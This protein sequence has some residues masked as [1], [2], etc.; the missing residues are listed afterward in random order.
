MV[1]YNTHFIP[2]NK[3][4]E[5]SDYIYVYDDTKLVGKVKTGATTM[6][7]LGEKLYSF[8]ALSDVHVNN[9]AQVKQRFEN[10]IKYFTDEEQAA[11]TCIAG[12]LTGSGTLEH[13]QEYI[14]SAI[15]AIK[16]CS[17]PAIVHDTTGNHDVQQIYAPEYF[18]APYLDD[19]EIIEEEKTAL[20]I[21]KEYAETQYGKSY[22]ELGI[23][24]EELDVFRNR[25]TYY[26]F[27]QGDDVFIM[28]GMYGWISKTGDTFTL[29]SLK[30]LYETLEANRNKRCFVFEHCP[31]MIYVNAD[32]GV[33]KDDGSGKPFNSTTSGSIL[34]LRLPTGN[35][36]NQGTYGLPF[37]KLMAH[38][39]NVIWFHGHSHMDFHYQQ[40]CSQVNYDKNFGCHS[41]HIPSL[42]SGRR[43]KADGSGWENPAGGY[44]YVVDVYNGHIVLRGRDFLN[45]EF[46]PITTFYLDTTLQ[47]IE[48]STFTEITGITTT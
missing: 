29:E 48:A 17:Q 8:G 3:A 13:Y 28:F 7:P 11:F 6:P 44:G 25:K 33:L 39:K 9:S 19:V 36:L 37:R 10:T 18:L 26:S 32:T 15:M 20:D 16:S 34:G 42:A 38:Y 35:L 40:Q 2:Q 43:L 41:I 23:T 47:E 22:E 12:D 45:N 30:W 14:L 4:P 31:S 27:T 1:K 5:N 21:F 46:A 24:D